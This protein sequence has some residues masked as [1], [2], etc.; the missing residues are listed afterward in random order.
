MHSFSSQS[1]AIVLN[2]FFLGKTID[3]TFIY[4]PKSFIMQIFKNSLERI[5]SYKEILI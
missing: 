5:Q 1:G 4:L 3:I 2:E